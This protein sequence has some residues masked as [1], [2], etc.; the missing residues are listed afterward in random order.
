MEIISEDINI[1]KFKIKGM[2]FKMK[3]VRFVVRKMSKG[4]FN[5]DKMD[6][7]LIREKLEKAYAGHKVEKGVTVKY[8]TFNGV[9]VAVLRRKL[10]RAT[11]LFT[12]FMEVVCG[13][14][15]GDRHTA[16]PYSSN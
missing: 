15:T 2:S 13:L 11:I 5:A 9:E 16:G 7:R 14:V 4:M 6:V 12:M 10:P 8:E 1:K 3:F